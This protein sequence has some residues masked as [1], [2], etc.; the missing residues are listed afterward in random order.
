M[1]PLTFTELPPSAKASIC[2]SF[3]WRGILITIASSLTGAV[4]GGIAGVVL[5]LGGIPKAAPAAGGLVGLVAG[6]LFVYLYVR[7]LLSSRLG[8]Y[9]L[10]LVRADEAA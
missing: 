10:L 2:W 3:F 4:L 6:V 9:R 8:Q 7:W 5:G 1:S